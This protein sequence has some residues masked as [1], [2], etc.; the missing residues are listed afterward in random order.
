[1]YSR[2]THEETAKLSGQFFLDTASRLLNTLERRYL[3]NLDKLHLDMNK[4]GFHSLRNVVVHEIKIMTFNYA[5]AFFKRDGKDGSRVSSANK[6]FRV[7]LVGINLN[8]GPMIK[9]SLR[10]LCHILVIGA[11]WPNLS[12]VKVLS[13]VVKIFHGSL[14]VLIW[15]VVTI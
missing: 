10:F 14:C 3:D 6:N 15:N 11:V 4:L 5:Y 2:Y 9:N 1:M 7:H 13:L 12:T 8:N